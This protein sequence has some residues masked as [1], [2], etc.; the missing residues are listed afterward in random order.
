MILLCVLY[1]LHHALTLPFRDGTA[2]I[3][4]TISLLSLVFLATVNAFFASFL[5]LA[6]SFND[7]FKFWWNF[8]EVVELVIVGAVPLVVCLILAAAVF[9]QLCRLILVVS[10]Y[11]RNLWWVCFMWYSNSFKRNWRYE[12]SRVLREYVMPVPEHSLLKLQVQ[13]T[14]FRIAWLSLIYYQNYILKVC[15]MS[16]FADWKGKRDVTQRF[17]IAR[18]I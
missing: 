16:R 8:C 11:L 18:R 17:E 14:N 9:S 4:E 6:V 12:T 13:W 5:S 2:N 10:V 7:H 15:G 3:L 1:L